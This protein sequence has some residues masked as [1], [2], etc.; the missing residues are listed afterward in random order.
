MRQKLKGKV[1]KTVIRPAMLYGALLLLCYIFTKNDVCFV[2]RHIDVTED[3]LSRL[4]S[5]HVVVERGSSAVECRTRIR[6]SPGSNPSFLAVRSSGGSFSPRRPSSVS[7]M[8]EYVSESSSLVIAAWLECFPE[9]LSW[10]R[11][12]QVCWGVKCKAL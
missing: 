2:S 7:C 9:K 12:E 5:C 10:C 3:T 8:I 6:N 1:Y 4:I 11:N